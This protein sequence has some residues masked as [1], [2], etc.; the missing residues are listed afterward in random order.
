MGKIAVVRSRNFQRNLCSSRFG[1]F[2]RTVG[3]LLKK[4]I[5]MKE[6][7]KNQVIAHAN[8]LIIFF[9]LQGIETDDQK[10]SLCKKLRR[11]ENKTHILMETRCNCTNETE[12]IG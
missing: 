8:D 5:K 6:T 9:N 10:I 4:V 12:E 11:L 3:I 7:I 1:I 2:G